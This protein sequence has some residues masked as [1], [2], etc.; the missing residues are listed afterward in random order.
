MRE[1][2]WHNLHNL[3]FA[4]KISILGKLMQI[5]WTELAM[6]RGTDHKVKSNELLEKL[7]GM[8]EMSALWNSGIE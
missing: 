7:E 4:Q 8:S 5:R 3:F 2:K 1:M 6:R